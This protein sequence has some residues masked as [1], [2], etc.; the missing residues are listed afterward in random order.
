MSNQREPSTGY[1]ELMAVLFGL[2]HLAMAWF[3]SAVRHVG[4]VW[5]GLIYGAIASVWIGGA[6]FLLRNRSL[7]I[8]LIVFLL[9]G[10]AASIAMLFLAEWLAMHV[11]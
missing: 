6:W 10:V 2:L 7:A 3:V 1:L 9:F 5:A 8:A 11:S 4:S